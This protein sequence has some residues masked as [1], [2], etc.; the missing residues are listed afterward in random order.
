MIK[1]KVYNQQ[2]KEVGEDKL[3]E[4]IFK[5]EIKPMV[6]QQA[7]VAQQANRRLPIAHV[8]TRA[9][10]RGGGRKPWAQKG[11]GR[12]RVGSIR[13]PLWRG[14]GKSFGPRKDR[15]FSRKM[16]KKAKR[17]A[18]LI[19]LSDKVN[20]KKII[21]LDKLEI[22]KAKTKELLKTF[23]KLPVKKTI[24]LVIP[25]VDQNII[26]SA[27]N[28]PYVKVNYAY[29]LN[30]IDILNHE[31]LVLPQESLKVIEK[32]YIKQSESPKSVKP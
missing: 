26:R 18:L 20:N 7:V 22:S 19:S 4:D 23:S 17:Q 13:S 28:L 24:L 32:I 25:R 14:G 31:Y 5:Q 11:T 3:S 1:I 30:L 2:G 21:L 27:H 10:V 29:S 12:A 9:E 16:N 15:N 6:V 8:K